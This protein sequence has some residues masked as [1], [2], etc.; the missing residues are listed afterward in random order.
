M[1][2]KDKPET[3]PSPSV[4]DIQAPAGIDLHPKPQK[5]VRLS[6]LAGVGAIVVGLGI[7][8]S[9]RLRRISAAATGTGCS[10]RF[11]FAK[12]CRSSNNCR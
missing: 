10:A 7:S 6:K 11:W 1:S 12:V 3:P 5:T 8:S 9:V 2:P 4:Q